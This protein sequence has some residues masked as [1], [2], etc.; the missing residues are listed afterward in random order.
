MLVKTIMF[1]DVA[2]DVVV[3]TF[4]GVTCCCF[5]IYSLL[6]CLLLAV[7]VKTALGN[8]VVV[9]GVVFVVAVVSVVNS[10]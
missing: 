5:C 10:V 6:Y 8:V 1:V 3:I 7:A 9:V 2:V 4:A